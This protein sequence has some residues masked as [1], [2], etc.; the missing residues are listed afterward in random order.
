M[1]DESLHLLARVLLRVCSLPNTYT[2]LIRLGALFPPHRDRNRLLRAS[3]RVRGRGTCLTRALAVAARAPAADVVIGI[4]PR[5][6]DRFVAHAW[7]E[8]GGEPVDPAEVTG[9]EIA[10]LRKRANKPR[11]CF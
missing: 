2:T 6:D 11:R 1:T 5:E 4:P 3:D 7:L 10:R 8:L 9:P